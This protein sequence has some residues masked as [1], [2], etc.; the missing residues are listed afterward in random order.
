MKNRWIHG[1]EVDMASQESTTKDVKM[2]QL[3]TN[4]EIFGIIHDSVFLRKNTN[5]VM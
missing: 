1:L 2:L 4:V 5:V 3:P